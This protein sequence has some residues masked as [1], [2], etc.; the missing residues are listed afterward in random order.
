MNFKERSPIYIQIIEKIKADIV[1]G[2][3]KGGEK[4]PSVRDF[5]ESFQVNP[6]TVQRVFQELEK[7][8]I[9]YSQRGIGTF[10]VDGADLVNKLKNAQAQKYTKR[11]INEMSSLGMNKDEINKYLLKILE[12]NSNEYS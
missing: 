3:I 2:K 4:L 1:S 7:E 11:F 6:N 9:A 8:N 12:A 5:S 10:I